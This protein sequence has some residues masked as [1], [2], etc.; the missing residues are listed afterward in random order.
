MNDDLF[1]KEGVTIPAHEFEITTSRAGGPGGQHVNKT[2]SRI[3][4]RWNVHRSS[5][6][7]DVQKARVLEKLKSEITAEGDVMVSNSS[8]RS[9]IQNKKMAFSTL[10]QKIYYALHIPK[11]RM[12]SSVPRGVKEKRFQSKKQRSEIKKMRSKIID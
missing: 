3:T 1:I 6:L 2:D 4:I 9:Q 7:D 12:K 8:S 10:A 11:K 5:A